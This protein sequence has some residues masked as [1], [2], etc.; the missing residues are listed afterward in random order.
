MSLDVSEPRAQHRVGEQ[1][2]ATDSR[3]TWSVREGDSVRRLWKLGVALSRLGST[4]RLASLVSCSPE[5]STP[6]S[7]RRTVLGRGEER[8]R[9]CALR[10]QL[11]NPRVIGIAT[12]RRPP[13][14]QL[15][16]LELRLRTNWGQESRVV[17]F[18]PLVAYSARTRAAPSRTACAAS[19][20]RPPCRGRRP[21][22][23]LM[24]PEQTTRRASHP[25]RRRSPRPFAASR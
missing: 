2:H 15:L 7:L 3:S 5:R 20:H 1:A 14:L 16:R 19:P 9:R 8:L 10:G 12:S 4:Q 24:D 18:D 23:R 11:Q 25:P 21:G 22:G 17:Q 13:A 6:R